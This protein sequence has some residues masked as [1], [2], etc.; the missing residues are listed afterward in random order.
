M[1][2]HIVISNCMWQ[3]CNLWVLCSLF[4]FKSWPTSF[5]LSS[6]YLSVS[7]YPIFELEF[8]NCLCYAS[9]SNIAYDGMSN[10]NVSLFEK[11]WRSE[12]TNLSFSDPQH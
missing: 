7:P 10:K 6:A 8:K 3:I 12:A 5:F 9:V 4:V 11:L 1:Q 2:L